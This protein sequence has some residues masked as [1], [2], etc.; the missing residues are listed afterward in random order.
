MAIA[1]GASASSAPIPG[2]SQR[3]REASS[4]RT[5]SGLPPEQV[6]GFFDFA[7]S[8]TPLGRTGRDEEVAKVVAFLASDESSF[9]N[10]SEVF[11]DGGLAQI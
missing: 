1:S 2:D 4:S 5:E 11:I 9:V 6:G 7:A 3:S 10:G 8:I